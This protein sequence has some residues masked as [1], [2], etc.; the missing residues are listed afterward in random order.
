MNPSIPVITGVGLVT[1]LGRSAEATWQSLLA[2]RHV[3]DHTRVEPAGHAGLPSV[4]ALAIEAA[5]QA[6]AEAGWDPGRPT[7][8]VCCTSK[9][10]V[11]QWMRPPHPRS[12]K[13]RSGGGVA[14]DL[15][16]FGFGMAPV[17]AGVA[18]TL[19]LGDGP[20]LTISAA[21]AGGLQALARAALLIHGGEADRVL[22]VAAEASALPMFIASFDRLGVLPPPGQLCRPYDIDR[23]GFLM[24]EAAAAVCLER[25]GRTI[26]T[27]RPVGVDRF[28]IGADASHLTGVD[29]SG[30]HLR[31]LVAAVVD[32]NPPDLI[33]GHGTGTEMNDAAELAAFDAA[34]P[35]GGA[36]TTLYSHKGAIGHTLGASGLVSVAISALCH[37]YATVPP[38]PTTRWPARTRLHTPT[39]VQSRVVRHSVVC[40]AGFG[41][42]IAA[43][44]LRSA[45]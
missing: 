44:S 13:V 3:T 24:S 12:D 37:R 1:P 32:G 4:T 2:G 38:M 40:A 36:G 9:G 33:H 22:V 10:P 28:A 20:R 31:R 45:D 30:V 6:V 39:A 5:E 26:D 17:T 16:R 19:Q 25:V 21:C 11:E 8:V 14:F 15:D 29:R 41:G 18:A 34:L 23:Q 42:G 43:I 7:A 27:V 35:D